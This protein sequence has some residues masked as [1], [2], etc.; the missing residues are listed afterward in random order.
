MDEV[1]ETF[2]LSQRLGSI[3]RRQL[4]AALD[5]F[6]AGTLL[7]AEPIPFGLFGQNVVLKTDRGEY[8]LRC[9]SHYP[10]QFP[11]ERFFAR[12]LHERTAVPVPWPYQVET[13][14]EIFGW[15]FALMPALPDLRLADPAVRASLSAED[16][17]GIARALGEVLA[18]L[19]GAQLPLAGEY[20][21]AADGIVP[22][23]VPWPERIA[24]QVRHSLAAARRHSD[25]TTKADVTWVESILADASNALAVPFV[26][27][28]I[29]GD[30]AWNNTLAERTETGWRISGVVDLM[31]MYI[32]DG[33]MDL[34]LV[35]RMY[36]DEGRLECAAAFLAAYLERRPPRPHFLPR[37]RLYV[38]H[39]LLIGWEYGQ[40]HPELNWWDPALTLQECLEPI[41]D[42]TAATAQRLMVCM[43]PGA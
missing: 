39:Y 33:E 31:N 34:A 26:P 25:R 30:F 23:D 36:V 21:L 42:E 10:W 24:G 27:V 5:R 7:D 32:G 6:D 38:L 8:V 37:F 15:D 1:P 13:S 20:G 3:T 29:H 40:R 12:L 43:P 9:W 35:P 18:E 11:K 4:Q 14:T 19:H 22:L 41:L 2:H 16:E 17:S 28:P